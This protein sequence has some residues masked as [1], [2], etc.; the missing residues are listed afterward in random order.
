MTETIGA[1]T[2][3][4][5]L[6]CDDGCDREATIVLVTIADRQAEYLCWVDLVARCARIAMEM[7]NA[8]EGA[9]L[10]A[11]APD[12]SMFPPETAPAEQSS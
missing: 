4:G 7:M 3:P 9:D 2:L 11:V 5:P 1:G 10:S 8:P 12:F 6:T